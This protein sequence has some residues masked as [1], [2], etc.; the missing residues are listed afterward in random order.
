MLIKGKG[1]IRQ[2]TGYESPDVEY[3]HRST[4]SI[5]YAVDGDG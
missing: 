4:L 5:T 2:R 3:K 1:K